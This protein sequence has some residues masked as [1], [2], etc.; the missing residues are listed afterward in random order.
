MPRFADFPA[1][2]EDATR[3]NA[4]GAGR[5]V[6]MTTSSLNKMMKVPEDSSFPGSSADVISVKGKEVIG[7][8]FMVVEAIGAKDVSASFGERIAS[9]KG[10]EGIGGDITVVEAAGNMDVP[11]TFSEYIT[12]VGGQGCGGQLARTMS[13]LRV[14]DGMF[15][16]PAAYHVTQRDSLWPT[17]CLELLVLAPA[18][19]PPFVAPVL[20]PSGGDSGGGLGL[21]PSPRGEEEFEFLGYALYAVRIWK[22]DILVADI[23]ELER[24]THQKSTLQDSVQRK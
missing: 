2:A 24:W 12:S 5:A 13:L 19:E 14:T 4:D 17:L 18:P 3:E 22:G 20:P 15:S 11:A 1:R 8:D 10:K 6:W 7:G 9:V 23:E 16:R 21:C